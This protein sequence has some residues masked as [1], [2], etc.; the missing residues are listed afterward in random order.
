MRKIFIKTIE[1]TSNEHLILEFF[2]NLSKEKRKHFI[3]IYNIRDHPT[4]KTNINVEMEYQSKTLEQLVLDNTPIDSKKC[5][6][7][8]FRI[9]HL[10]ETFKIIHQD[11]HLKNILFNPRK[12]KFFLIDF[13]LGKILKVINA[14]NWYEYYYYHLRGDMFQ[15]CWNFAF[16]DNKPFNNFQRYRKKISNYKEDRKNKLKQALQNSIFYHK[17]ICSDLC[18][19]WLTQF[20]DVN[21]P[22]VFHKKREKILFKCMIMRLYLVDHYINKKNLKHLYNDY[23]IQK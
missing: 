10:M 7:D 6:Q 20:F 15:F 23:M 9:F 12:K 1:K 19:T 11:V 13:G 5:F 16:H 18:D 2:H 3:Q 17:K 4:V 8:I 21:Y 22:L 14:T